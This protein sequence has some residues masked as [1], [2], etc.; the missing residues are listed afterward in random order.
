MPI[1][2]NRIPVINAFHRQVSYAEVVSVAFDAMTENNLAQHYQDT[3][4]RANEMINN[5]PDYWHRIIFL[6]DT[7]TGKLK[8]WFD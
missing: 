3:L 6:E 8:I 7:K 5:D 2:N 4:N 1:V